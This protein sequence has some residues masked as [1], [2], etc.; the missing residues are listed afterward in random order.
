MPR[1]WLMKSEPEVYSLDDLVR[2]R[3]TGWEG[4]RNYQAR[5]YMRD[6]MA[7]G[8]GVLFYH[9]GAVP[10]G[11]A[12][13]ARVLRVGLA[14]PTAF[15]PKSPYYDPRSDPAAP[16]WIMVEVGFVEK[17]PRFVSLPELR[18]RPELAGL[19][20]LARGQRISVQPVETEHYRRICALGRGRDR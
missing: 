20:V 3:R 19:A 17:F 15:D 5:N 13:L 18:A 12:G 10:P 16:R 4:V 7:V 11:V 2:D 8:D 6:E 14:D 9:S 1:Y